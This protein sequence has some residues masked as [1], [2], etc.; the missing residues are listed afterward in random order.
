ML[1]FWEFPQNMEE[2]KTI[3]SDQSP[4]CMRR[5]SDF[6]VFS[7]RI[8][9]EQFERFTIFPKKPIL[10]ILDDKLDPSEG[11]QGKKQAYHD[12]RHGKR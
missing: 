6:F 5:N 11:G 4:K 2:C 9:A 7:P 10:A 1:A 8:F 12:E 3:L